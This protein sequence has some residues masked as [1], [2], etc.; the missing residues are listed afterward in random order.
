MKLWH[1]RSGKFHH[2]FYPIKFSLDIDNVNIEFT[3][4]IKV[5]KLFVII[6]IKEELHAGGIE[7]MAMLN[8]FY[9]DGVIVKKPVLLT[10]RDGK[11]YTKVTVAVPRRGGDSELYFMTAF[12]DVAERITKT[13]DRYDKV[14]FRG[15]LRPSNYAD[16]SGNKKY[17]LELLVDQFDVYYKKPK[18][19]N[20]K[21]VEPKVK[22]KKVSEM[23]EEEKE[24]LYQQYKATPESAPFLYFDDLDFTLPK[25]D[26]K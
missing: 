19:E 14:N 10:S 4:Y 2:Y 11:K 12:N 17:Q 6:K 5:V 3:I 26:K 21:V 13:C 15:I 20:G 1:G 23:T 22:T 25:K 18:D 9:L 24:E 8:M 16:A 7:I